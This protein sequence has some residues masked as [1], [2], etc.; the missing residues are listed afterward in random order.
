MLSELRKLLFGSNRIKTTN[1]SVRPAYQYSKRGVS[2]TIVSYTATNTVEITLNDL[3]QVGRVIDAATQSGA[4]TV[5]K[6]EYGL[7]NSR[8]LRIQAL[9]EAAAEAKASVEAIAAGLGLR[10]LRVISAEE[11]VPEDGFAMKKK[12]LPPLPQGPAPITPV[13]PG[14]I[15]VDATV[16]LRVE[17]GE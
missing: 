4:N 16:I 14:T 1:Y 6:L 2:A 8:A 13:E 11:G 12:A 10:V 17:I 3:A 15:E 5:Q 7:K 9:R